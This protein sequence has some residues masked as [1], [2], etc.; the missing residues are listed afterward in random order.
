MV[1]N[2][3][4]GATVTVKYKKS[5]KGWFPLEGKTGTITIVCKAKR[6]RNHGVMID[7]QLW[8]VPCG[9]LFYKEK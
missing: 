6:C 3:S 1:S 4:I 2:P 9:N 7:G 5:L 8:V